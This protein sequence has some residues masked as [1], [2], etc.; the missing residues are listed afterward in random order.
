MQNRRWLLVKYGISL[1]LLIALVSLVASAQATFIK[2][3]TTTGANYKGV[4]GANGSAIAL[5]S[6]NPPSGASY[7]VINDSTWTWQSGAFGGQC[8]YNTS[9]QITLTYNGQL[10]LYAID[11]DNQGRTETV[12]VNGSS[13]QTVSSFTKGT[14]LVYKVAGTITFTIT[15]N[16]GPNAVV[17]AIF[18][19]VPTALPPPPSAHSVIISWTAA[20]GATGYNVY[21]MTPPG[22]FAKINSTVVAAPPYTDSTVVAGGTYSYAVTSLNASGESA[23]APVTTFV[24][25]TP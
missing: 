13:P 2:L 12:T 11:W 20:T 16:A 4:Y 19:D 18:F 3:D 7:T 15:A 1:A 10:E 25:P 21:R 22:S 6:S 8:W 14:Y 17:S 23:Q 24:I 5:T 9:F